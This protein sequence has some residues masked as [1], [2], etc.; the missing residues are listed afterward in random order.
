MTVIRDTGSHRLRADLLLLLAAAI[1]GLAFVAQRVGMRHLE[2]LTFNG[3]RFALG[4]AVLVPW[5]LRGRAGSR[6]LD[7]LRAGLPGGLAAGAVLFAGSTLQQWGVVTTT[8]GKAGFITGLYVVLVPLLGLVVGQR[9]GRATWVG[10]TV[11]TVGLYLLSVRGAWHMAHGDLLVLAGAF[12]WAA[13]VLVVG[14][15]AKRRHPAAIAFLQFA[16]CSALSLAGAFV[17]EDPR[18][19]AVVA[20]ALPILYA[21]LL[22][23]GVAYTLQV[24]AQRHAPPAHAAIILSL[25]TVFAVLGGWILLGEQLSSRGLAGCAL[26]LIGMLVSQTGELRR[27]GRR[28]PDP[29][30]PVRAVGGPAGAAPHRDPPR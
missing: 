3:I 10:A 6:P 29:G 8:A 26:M 28:R 13:H 1:W 27:P 7:E 5:L 18:P 12:F 23:V 30:A 24:V 17:L 22:S 20:A 9:P 15:L 4:A 21:G 25:E 11:A 2:P 16:T 14:R 19:A